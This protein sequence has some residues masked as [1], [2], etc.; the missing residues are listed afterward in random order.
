MKISQNNCSK[1]DRQTLS[2]ILANERSRQLLAYLKTEGASTVRDIAVSLAATEQNCPPSE[3]SA[4]AIKNWQTELQHN[5]LPRLEAANLIDCQVD[6]HVR[7]ISAPL[8][9]FDVELPAISEPTDPSW[10]GATAVL[11]RSYR[12]Q[13]LSLVVDADGPISLLQLAGRLA[14]AEP[15][16][17]TAATVETPQAVS[18]VLHHIDLPKLDDIGL[19]EYDCESRTITATPAGERLL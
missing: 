1:S 11:A 17:V 13:L 16:A 8:D 15:D 14:E 9:R 3:L 2:A 4:P 12:Q 5:Y 18:V 7:Y 6:G 10:D 19:L